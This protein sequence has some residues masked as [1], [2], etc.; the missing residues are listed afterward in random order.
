MDAMGN[1]ARSRFGVTI[2]PLLM[3]ALPVGLAAFLGSLAT[4]PSIPT[5]YA[6]LEKPFFTPP[7]WLFAPVWTLLYAMMAYAAYRVLRLPA[8]TPGRRRAL[9]VF[10]GQLFLN[11]AWSFAFFAFRSPEAGLAV[12]AAL[13]AGIV[14]TLRLFAPL[15]RTA[16]WLLVPYLAWV[17]YASAVNLAFVVLN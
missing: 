17:S 7:N 14:W 10:Y 9:A 2:R 5:W 13:L 16:A 3:A 12:I 4:R 8:D 15:D 11:A 6:T 1:G